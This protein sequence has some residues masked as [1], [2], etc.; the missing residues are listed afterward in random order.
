[1]A[2]TALPRQKL[3]CSSVTPFGYRYPHGHGCSSTLKIAV[4]GDSFRSLLPAPESLLMMIF[5]E[6]T[7]VNLSHIIKLLGPER[8]SVTPFDVA[9]RSSTYRP[10]QNRTADYL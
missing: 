3:Q 5:R 2:M 6:V 8:L 9:L 1:M 4:Q 7:R 10:M